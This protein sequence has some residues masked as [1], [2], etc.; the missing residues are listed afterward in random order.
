MSLIPF[1]FDDPFVDPFSASTVVRPTQRSTGGGNN[2]A[3][4]PA[5]QDLSRGWWDWNR[6]LA[7]PM[8]MSLK[9]QGNQYVMDVQAPGNMS[10]NDIKIDLHD[11][12]L[13]LTGKHSDEQRDEGE[14]GHRFSSS[15][16]SFTRSMKLPKNVDQSRIAASYGDNGR[17]EIALPKREK[18]EK[19]RRTIAISGQNKQ[20]GSGGKRDERKVNE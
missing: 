14:W 5:T 19:S 7:E 6:S 4:V 2:S 16:T 10:G 18:D 9:D 8:T 20:I 3:L 11:D 12:V 17:I 15:S 1:F 13:T